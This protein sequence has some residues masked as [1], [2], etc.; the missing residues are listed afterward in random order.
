MREAVFDGEIVAFDDDG[1]PSFER[2]QRRMQ[3]HLAAA[4]CAGLAASTPVVYAIFDLLYLD[5]HSLMAL[6]YERA[7]RSAWRGSELGGPAWR[8]PAEPSRTRPRRC[9]TPPSAQGLEGVVAKRLDSR[10]EPGRRNRRLGEDQAR[11]T[12]RSS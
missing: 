9:S 12:A 2:L 10:Y 8:V 1:R 4:P 6:P 3:R 5:G 7:A 11:L